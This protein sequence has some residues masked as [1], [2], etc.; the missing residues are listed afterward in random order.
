ME[1]IMKRAEEAAA[2]KNG[3]GVVD[4]LNH[5][6]AKIGMKLTEL[7]YELPE[8]DWPLFFA[9]VKRTEDAAKTLLDEEGLQ[10]MRLLEKQLRLA[11]VDLDAMREQGGTSE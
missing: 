1:S 10:I 4:A 11:V 2:Q 9:A 3:R 7:L 5:G 8:E 6:V